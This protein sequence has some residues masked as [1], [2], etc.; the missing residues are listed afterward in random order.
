MR[1]T[2]DGDDGSKDVGHALG[3]DAD[4]ESLEGLIEVRYLSAGLRFEVP[5][6]EVGQGDD[7]HRSLL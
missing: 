6:S 7:W 4:A 5:D 1:P 2:G 3:P